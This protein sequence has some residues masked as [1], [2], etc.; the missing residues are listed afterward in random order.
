MHAP[1]VVPVGSFPA[2][3]RMEL[4]ADP[5]ESSTEARWKREE[6]LHKKRGI[7]GAGG[8]VSDYVAYVTVPVLVLIVLLALLRLP[9]C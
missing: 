8:D 6:V 7:T 5:D 4:N 3:H 2:V 1:M 9:E